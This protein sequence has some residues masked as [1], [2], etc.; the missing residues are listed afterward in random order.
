MLNMHPSMCVIVITGYP[1]LEDTRTTFKLRVFDYLSKPF[2]LAQLRQT[3]SNAVETGPGRF[4]PPQRVADRLHRA[5]REHAQPGK[6]AGHLPR[7]G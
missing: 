5:R 6:P 3:L 1:S 2:T 7:L 4:H